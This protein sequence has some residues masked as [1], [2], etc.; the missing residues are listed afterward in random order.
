M[1]LWLESHAASTMRLGLGPWLGPS[2]DTPTGGIMLLVVL[3]TLHVP[4]LHRIIYI[5]LYI[6]YY[7]SPFNRDFIFHTQY[8]P[9]IWPGISALLLV[10]PLTVFIVVRFRFSD[11]LNQQLI[12][13]ACHITSHDYVPIHLGFPTRLACRWDERMPGGR[14]R[15]LWDDSRSTLHTFIT[16]YTLIYLLC[17]CSIIY[18][19][20]IYLLKICMHTSGLF[21]RLCSFIC[22][23]DSLD[24]QTLRYSH[25]LSQLVPIKFTKVFSLEPSNVQNPC[26]VMNWHWGSAQIYPLYFGDYHNSAGQ[27]METRLFNMDFSGA[28]K[29][30]VDH[31][32]HTI[33]LR[34]SIMAGRSPN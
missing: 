17:I 25:W 24:Q 29:C 12:L 8:I 26:W 20:C 14:R 22:L 16:M 9:M 2:L 18:S 6:S 1:D 34:Y 7:I 32:F 23:G 27:S 28:A 13:V 21:L 19:I 11:P 31:H 10:K 33:P 30:M 4:W 15:V 5:V 3:P